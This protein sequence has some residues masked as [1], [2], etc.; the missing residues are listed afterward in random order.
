MGI[1]HVCGAWHSMPLPTVG[2]CRSCPASLPRKQDA[3][4][5]A[6]AQ[7]RHGNA[8]L[9]RC[10]EKREPPVGFTVLC[11]AKDVY[12]DVLS[13]PVQLGYHRA[14]QPIRPQKAPVLPAAQI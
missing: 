10:T 7:E 5:T 11:G 6:Q 3:T 12:V 8:N 4:R 9:Q 1:E 2:Q 14:R 13:H